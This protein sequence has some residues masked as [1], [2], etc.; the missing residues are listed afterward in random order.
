[1]SEQQL[2]DV[3]PAPARDEIIIALLNALFYN[4]ELSNKRNIGQGAIQGSFEAELWGCEQYVRELE[5]L[6]LLQ[7]N[8]AA[9]VH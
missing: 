9:G 1:M 2:K 7:I 3:P 5:L 4:S 6:V 8:P